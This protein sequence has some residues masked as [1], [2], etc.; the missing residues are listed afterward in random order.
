MI[1]IAIAVVVWLVGVAYVWALCRSAALG[2]QQVATKAAWRAGRQVV[3]RPFV[4]ER[5]L[6]LSPAM[7]RAIL[8][9]CQSTLHK[10]V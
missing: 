3:R 1:A 6:R 7:R 4:A 10:S 2:D 8:E 9:D 5:R